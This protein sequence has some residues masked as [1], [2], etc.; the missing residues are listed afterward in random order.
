VLVIE[1]W[2]GPEDPGEADLELLV[3]LADLPSP[4]ADLDRMDTLLWRHTER[5]GL[6]VLAYPVTAADLATPS[7]PVLL[8]AGTGA[9]QVT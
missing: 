1:A 7:S 4:W 5:T 2:A 3:V 8:R 9:L 6:T